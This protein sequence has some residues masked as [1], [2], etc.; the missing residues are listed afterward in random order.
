MKHSSQDAEYAAIPTASADV[1][2][3]RLDEIRRE[4]QSMSERPAALA[5]RSREDGLSPRATPE[6]GYYGRPLLKK[7]QWTREIPL[8]FFCG[9]AAGAAAIIAAVAGAT[10]RNE[11]VARDARAIA[12]IGGV[13]SPALLISDLGMPSRFLNM[14]RVFKVQSPMS[15]GSWT[16]AAFSS[17]S[18]AAAFLHMWKRNQCRTSMRVLQNV[19][20]F[21]SA[22]TGAVIATY[23]GVLLGATAIPV[24]SQNAAILPF[25]FAASG[26]AAA[27]ALLELRGQESSAL[28]AIG[29][30]TSGA[31]A[32]VGASIELR[33]SPALK[34]LK[35]GSSGWL[36]RIGGLLSGPIPIVFRLLA[37]TGKKERSR[38][39]RKIAAVSTVAGSLATRI[40]WTKAG[41]ASAGDTALLLRD[42]RE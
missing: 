31:E 23:T 20:Q 33:K 9:G 5:H 6:A 16:L 40:A 29:I 11:S 22:I 35:S 32:F 19:S 10:G 1:R 15:V 26:M 13:I 39:Y 42:R 12:A 2:E 36:A 8:Y 38:R 24:W 25:H 30:V 34:P 41:V 21:L 17:S 27:G 18:A 28:N 37:L 7:P 14:L 4:A 3:A